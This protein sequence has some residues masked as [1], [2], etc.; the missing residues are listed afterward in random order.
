MRKIYYI[1]L[2]LSLFFLS[3]TPPSKYVSRT[4]HIHVESHSRFLDVVADN[5]QVYCEIQ[6]SA[7]QVVAR[8][9][10]KSFEFK[11]GALD[12]AF[13]SDRVN[14]SEF[15]KFRYEGSIANLAQINFDKPGNYPVRVNGVLY[16]GS[17]QR[18]TSAQ[19][20]LRISSDGTLRAETSFLMRI[21]EES[22][23]TINRLMKE[24]LPSV[25]ALDANKLGISRDIQLTLNANFRARG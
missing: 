20:V 7:G 15:T 22:V 5:F 2:F 19:G 12:R 16:V 10:I 18:I 25:I 21:E 23:E 11:M 4:G 17:Y 14:L 13:N 9:L 8:G 1:F 6:P 24:K 3:F